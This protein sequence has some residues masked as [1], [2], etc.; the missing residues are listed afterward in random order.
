MDNQEERDIFIKTIILFVTSSGVIGFYNIF[1]DKTYNS[2]NAREGIFI[3]LIVSLSY[4]MGRLSK[5][6]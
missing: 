3:C 1:I 2:A 6:K 5:L 4:Y